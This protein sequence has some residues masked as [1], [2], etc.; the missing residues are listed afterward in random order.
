MSFKDK[1][2]DLLGQHGD[3]VDEAIE[4]AGDMVDRKTG[5]KYEHQVDMAQEQARKYAERAGG[6]RGPEEREGGADPMGG[7]PS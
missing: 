7:R 4:K 2:K 3:K 6:E 5:G 1:V